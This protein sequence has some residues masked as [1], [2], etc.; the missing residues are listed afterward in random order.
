MYSYEIMQ[1][2]IIGLSLIIAIGP[3]NLFVINQGLKKDNVFLVCAICSLSDSLLII[4][5]IFISVYISKI[6]QN[7]VNILIIIGSCWLFLYGILKIKNSF[8]IKNINFYKNA[9]K[10]RNVILTTL[11]FTFLNPHVYLDTIVLIGSIS[12]NFENKFLFGLGAIIS[13]WLFFFFLGYFSKYL[14]KF[15]N[16]KK[17]LILIDVFFGFLMILYGVIFII[18]I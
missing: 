10:K 12:L 16:N 8:K 13:S 17:R 11:A 5:G 6:S 4:I 2:M 7:S 18:N 15:I 1:G 3:Q 9:Q 14:S